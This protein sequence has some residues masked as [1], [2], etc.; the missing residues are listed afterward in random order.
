MRLV[1]IA[2][3][4]HLPTHPHHPD[5][6]HGGQDLGHHQTREGFEEAPWMGHGGVRHMDPGHMGQC[7]FSFCMTCHAQLVILPFVAGL[8]GAFNREL[9]LLLSAACHNSS[10]TEVVALQHMRV[11]CSNGVNVDPGTQGMLH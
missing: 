4:K 11:C 1:Q 7:S 3:E 5:Q 9:L 10:C 6:Q 8:E 2:A